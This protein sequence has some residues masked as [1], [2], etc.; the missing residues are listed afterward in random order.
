[1][2]LSTLAVQLLTRE[3]ADAPNSWVWAWRIENEYPPTLRAAAEAWARQQPV[4]PV[5]AAGV[6]LAQ[7][8][9]ATGVSVPQAL[10]LLYVCTKNPGDGLQLLSRNAHR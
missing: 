10:E 6:S 7:I 5:E 2:Q 8:Q 4:P 9:Q 3:H 1:M